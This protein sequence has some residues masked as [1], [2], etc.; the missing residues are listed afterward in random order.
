MRFAIKVFLVSIAVAAVSFVTGYA[1][2][3]ARFNEV[4]RRVDE[5][6]ARGEVIIGPCG[7]D[8]IQYAFAYSLIAFVCRPVVLYSV[9]GARKVFKVLARQDSH[10]LHAPSE[11]QGFAQCSRFLLQ[12][13]PG[14]IF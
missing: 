11:L 5:A 3:S 7:P 14:E 10:K 9:L 8:P 12:R 4:C 6:F 2:K 1:V 13:T